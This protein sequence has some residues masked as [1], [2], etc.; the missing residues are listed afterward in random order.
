M[1]GWLFNTSTWP[2]LTISG[3]EPEFGPWD[4]VILIRQAYDRREDVRW[5]QYPVLST[6]RPNFVKNGGTCWRWGLIWKVN[7]LANRIIQ[8]TYLFSA[9]WTTQWTS[10]SNWWSRSAIINQPISA[11]FLK[12]NC[13]WSIHMNKTRMHSSRIRT[14]RCSGSLSCH[15]Q[16][17]PPTFATHASSPRTSPSPCT[18]LPHRGQTD[19]CEN[20][21]LPQLLLRTENIIDVI[22][23]WNRLHMQIGFYQGLY[24]CLH[25]VRAEWTISECHS[26][27]EL[28]LESS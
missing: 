20:I 27:S 23:G 25:Q 8:T 14:I 16:P 7:V 5:M 15:A 26:T 12:V 28:D 22:T 17:T 6:S 11:L 1:H 19:A 21:T 24:V 2:S 18:P 13:D 3:L 4:T 10:T 9:N